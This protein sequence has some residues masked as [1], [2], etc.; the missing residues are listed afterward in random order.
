MR[1][2][3]DILL[4]LAVLILTLPLS[5]LIA[6]AVKLSS[7]GPVLFV[8][9]RVGLGASVFRMYKFRSMRVTDKDHGPQLTADGDV[10][11]TAIGRTIRRMKLD[12]LPQFI[13]VLK[14]DM[15]VVGPRPEVPQYVAD[16]EP[17]MREIFRYKPGLADPA[18]IQFRDEPKM[19]AAAA[20][21]EETYVTEILPRKIAISLEYQ[22]NRSPLTD[23]RVIGET[24]LVILGR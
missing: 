13:N 12:E 14:G 1:R 17:W 7:Q 10:R 3:F 23:L 4:S 2:I 16:Y 9:E 5:L 6:V 20:D 15:T 21:R 19:L 8:Q 18:A 22:K 24:M 11:V